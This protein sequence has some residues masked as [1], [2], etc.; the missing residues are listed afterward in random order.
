MGVG[1]NGV[2]WNGGRVEWGR[3]EW[4]RVEWGIWIIDYCTMKSKQRKFE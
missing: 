1:W 4:G 3:V 2:E